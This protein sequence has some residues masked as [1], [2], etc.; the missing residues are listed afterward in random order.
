MKESTNKFINLLKTNFSSQESFPLH[1]PYFSGN[2]KKYVLE[3]LEST[4]VSS[5]GKI[6]DDFE[7]RISFYTKSKFSIACVNGTAALHTSLILAGVKSGDEVLTQALSFVATSNSIAYIGAAPVFIDV[8]IDTMGMSPNALNN[9][10]VE[11]TELREEGTFN[12][13]TG[14]K[15]AA[16]VPM[17][18]FGFM[19]RIDKIKKICKKHGISLIEDA[20]EALGS[21]YKGI[22][23]GKFGILSSFSF[24]GNKII[25]SGGGGCILTQNNELYKK[26]K[27]LT[28]TS[29]SSKNWE[30][31]HDQVGYNYRMPNINAA[32]ALA[33][34]EQ[35]DQKI[36][37]KKKLYNFY[38][39][40]L[41]DLGFELISIPHNTSW[42]YWLMSINL[43]NRR[44]RDDFLKE[45]NKQN[46]F[47]RPV[48]KLL[49]K[50]PMYSDCQR[51]AQLNAELL[52]KRVV[53]IPSNIK[54]G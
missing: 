50:L 8:D 26:A 47:T 52:E 12:K 5:K 13:K 16:C 6:L 32:L 53:N 25:T 17:H 22:S 18:T 34:L 1:E 11:H 44:E 30:Y 27:H 42:N 39:E 37:S 51:D 24:N 45:T 21:K 43:S 23:S 28:T 4:F 15:I 54:L 19:C 29:K 41:S 49:Y 36:L 14:K 40:N 20:A 48:W 3:A 46:I 31:I 38:E 7:N 33:Q 35:I 9:F 10:L 2:E